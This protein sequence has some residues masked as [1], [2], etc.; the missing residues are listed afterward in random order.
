MAEKNENATMA[1]ADADSAK[2][3]TL[4]APEE[5][6]L[7]DKT[8]TAL[9]ESDDQYPHGTKLV[10][11]AGASLVAVFLTALDQV[12]LQPTSPSP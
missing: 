11:L 3:S 10:L 12:R 9:Q 8:T 1:V 5:N 4:N 2:S 6:T 7:G